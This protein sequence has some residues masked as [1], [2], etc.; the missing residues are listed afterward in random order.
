MPKG[1]EPRKTP[2]PQPPPPGKGPKPGGPGTLR[3]DDG[4]AE[5]PQT[6]NCSS[7]HLR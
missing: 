7:S 6:Q 1:N 2:P 3:P 4:G 5:P